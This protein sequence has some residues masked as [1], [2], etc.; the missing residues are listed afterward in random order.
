MI[1]LLPQ[2]IPAEPGQCVI[3][4]L[5]PVTP[6]EQDLADLSRRLSM[7]C[8]VPGVP[9]FLVDSV[10][11]HHVLDGQLIPVW[12]VTLWRDGRAWFTS[13]MQPAAP[14]LAASLDALAG[15]PLEWAE[16]IRGKGPA[17]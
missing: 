11:Q 2:T 16:L 13:I 14:T 9:T 7:P 8:T 4:V 5:V 12:R 17:Q 3:R 15:F 6:K 1:A 10:G